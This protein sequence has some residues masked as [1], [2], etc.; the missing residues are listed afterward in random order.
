MDVAAVSAESPA[1][2]STEGGNQMRTLILL[3]LRVVGQVKQVSNNCPRPCPSTTISIHR[4]CPCPNSHPVQ[5]PHTSWASS[6]PTKLE[7]TSTRR[8]RFQK[9]HTQYKRNLYRRCNLHRFLSAC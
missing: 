4:P 1:P 5:L 2:N 8:H 9:C 7:R 6:K 3:S